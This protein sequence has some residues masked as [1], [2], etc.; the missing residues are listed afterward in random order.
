MSESVVPE[1]I[2]RLIRERGHVVLLT[3]I[4]PDG[5][6]LGSLFG[7]AD[8]LSQMGK[9]VF[10]YLDQPVSHL[11]DFLP[12][13]ERARCSLDALE[14]FRRRAGEKDLVT[15]VLDCGEDERLGKDKLLLMDT[16]PLIVVD[17]HRS[18]RNYGH[19]RWVDPL[20]SSTGEMVYEIGVALGH[21]FSLEAAFNI[22]VAIATDTGSFRYDCTRARTLEIA[23][24]LVA[25]GVRPE[26]VAAQIYDN[27][28]PGRLK[29][30]QLVLGTL[31]ISE[32]EQIA[33][34][35][36]TNE[37][38][39]RSG[40]MIQDIEGFVDF[41]RAIRSVRVAVFLK[42]LEGNRVSVSLRAKGAVDVADIAKEFGGGGHRNAAGC[43]FSGLSLEE[44]RQRL[45]QV[46]AERLA[47]HLP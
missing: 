23:G 46:I 47:S 5:D 18:H 31:D 40:A 33:C 25:R 44:V 37:M 29:L 15:V 13:C 9:K 43:R 12:G 16:E 39:E 17:H 20:R 38:L 11:Y 10:A 7:L 22:Y 28:S 32:D 30:L 34:I 42:E 24:K 41:P 19:L 27:F 36:V 8:M 45:H 4:H 6:A 1:D 35:H 14:D 21:R 2:L 3:H 26:Q